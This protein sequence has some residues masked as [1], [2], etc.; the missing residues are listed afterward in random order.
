M[1]K[2]YLLTNIL[3]FS[4]VMVWNLRMCRAHLGDVVDAE[5]DC[6]GVEVGEDVVNTA[7]VRQLETLHLPIRE[8]DC[9][10]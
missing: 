5:V 9:V 6:A 2:R 3:D 4:I 1:L 10:T 8:E 7:R